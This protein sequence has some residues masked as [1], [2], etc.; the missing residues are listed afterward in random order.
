MTMRRVRGAL[1]RALAAGV[2]GGSLVGVALLATPARAWKPQVGGGGLSLAGEPVR[3]GQTSVVGI[4]GFGAPV[5]AGPVA[6]TM[7]PRSGYL[8]D[9]QGHLI[10]VGRL[11]WAFR[12]HPSEALSFRPMENATATVYQ[13]TGDWA[14]ELVFRFRP[15][16]ADPASPSPYQLAV[17]YTMSAT[18]VDTTPVVAYPDPYDIRSGQN[19]SFYLYRP[20]DGLLSV[21]AWKQS[22]GPCDASAAGARGRIFSVRAGW[23]RIEWSR[24]WAD[25]P[26][27]TAGF[28]CYALSDPI[29]LRTLGGGAL[30]AVDGSR[31]AVLRVKVTGGPERRPVAGARVTV[32]EHGREAG[33]VSI[34]G[35]DGVARFDGLEAGHYRVGAQAPGYGYGER[36]VFLPPDAAPDVSPVWLHLLPVPGPRL[37][38]ALRPPPARQRVVAGDVAEVEL[39]VSFPP[40]GAETPGSTPDPGAARIELELDPALLVL[41]GSWHSAN[42]GR[43]QPTASG[44]VW[45]LEAPVPGQVAMLRARAVVTPLAAGKSEV[46]ARATGSLRRL[47]A[48]LSMEPVTAGLAL[49][50]AG[51]DRGGLV[52]GR[53]EG[54]TRTARR[55]LFVVA[56]DGS[57]AVA[58]EDGLFT[59]ALP[60][61]LHVL[62]VEHAIPHAL[63]PGKAGQP[64]ALVVDP[65]GISSVVLAAPGQEGGGAEAAWELSAVSAGRFEWVQGGRYGGDVGFTL[66]ASGPGSLA[67][68]SGNLS[69]SERPLLGSA[70]IE[71]VVFASGDHLV[72]I[73][74]LGRLGG[75]APA[76]REAETPRPLGDGG[77][78]DLAWVPERGVVWRWAPDGEGPAGPGVEPGVTALWRSEGT[79]EANESGE[80][81]RQPLAL[82]RAADAGSEGR[83]WAALRLDPDGSAAEGTRWL[84]G[85]GWDGS[86]G[87]RRVAVEVMRG[88]G[89]SGWGALVEGSL[90]PGGADRVQ[91]S[92]RH[93][94]GAPGGERAVPLS[95]SGSSGPGGRTE[96][97][98]RLAPGPLDG[99]LRSVG[100]GAGWSQAADVYARLDF[101][102][103]RRA[104]GGSAAPGPVLLKGR[105]G[106]A[107]D[108]TA[109][110]HPYAEAAVTL[111]NL[112][113]GAMQ[114]SAG[115]AVRAAGRYFA[116]VQPIDFWT[117]VSARPHDTL[118][119][120]GRA[121]L[122]A[123]RDRE[124]RL[125]PPEV[126]LRGEISP[127]QAV[128]LSTQA[129]AT[130]TRLQW[131][132]V[133]A[134]Y[135]GPGSRVEVRVTPKYIEAEA[136]L[137][138][139]D[140]VG[141]G[142]GTALPWRLSAS[143]RWPAHPA[144][145]GRRLQVEGVWAS[146][147]GVVAAQAKHEG[148]ASEV[149]VSASVHALRPGAPSATGPAG[150]ADA[151]APGAG[152]LTLY[153][154]ALWRRA[155]G[156]RPVAAVDTS[157]LRLGTRGPFG[158]AWGWFTEAAGAAIRGNLRELYRGVQAAA[159][160]YVLLPAG[161]GGML[162]EFGWRVVARS[163]GL[164]HPERLAPELQGGLFVRLT[165]WLMERYNMP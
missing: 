56:E 3:P 72:V 155:G 77:P 106:G 73:G 154:S 28:Y 94:D 70:R 108:G 26:V 105:I 117:E 68:A 50:E 37:A 57:F 80:G 142:A 18:T 128:R 111:P 42:A 163:P 109:A 139:P 148:E 115:G 82:V 16:W 33:R 54:S 88:S 143:A 92:L 29:T 150:E 145:S 101:A 66:E 22:T 34:A 131:E 67:R 49:G 146:G 89:G 86:V 104:A 84:A 51:I 125:A 64:V 121:T 144:A 119:L 78:L 91:L 138:R 17:D 21:A 62:R 13:G 158:N 127:G 36:D 27:K 25:F 4:V 79:L 116:G 98:W 132:Q 75:P 43:I 137:R 85:A 161:D 95:L 41:P 46:V 152:R 35:E 7:R 165:G 81:T 141:C 20:A 103:P 39:S 99:A 74:N 153:G 76:G 157:M 90:L 47:S 118:K 114:V 147:P 100:F 130:S 160:L 113:I 53:I 69:A 164:E 87:A 14:G 122:A 71:S 6:L 10:P 159:G 32:S 38:L 102:V 120:G 2:V 44:L 23:S 9:G 140:G 124:G 151:S 1:A 52:V 58:D 45:E 11:E 30:Q 133:T 24:S 156:P 126:R 65:G 134:S 19:L 96:V 83:V 135:S 110:V 40:E 123:G 55:P 93:L 60:A 136:A 15:T 8:G 129:L 63:A 107:F 112:R 5:E 162:A 97:E 48:V 61:G 149:S 12:R 31:T 59:M